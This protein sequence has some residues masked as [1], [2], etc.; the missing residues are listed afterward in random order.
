MQLL[1]HREEA[2]C[3][4]PLD[5]VTKQGTHRRYPVPDQKSQPQDHPDPMVKRKKKTP[6]RRTAGE[7]SETGHE[8][9]YS[10]SLDHTINHKWT[11]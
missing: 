5:H 1:K 11:Q 7:E 3:I 6:P 10:K 9:H 8:E 4:P 2:R